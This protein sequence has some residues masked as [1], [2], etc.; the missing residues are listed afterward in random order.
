MR[1]MKHVSSAGRGQ[2]SRK[3]AFR[4]RLWATGDA[5]VSGSKCGCRTLLRPGVGL[6]VLWCQSEELCASSWCTSL[7]LPLCSPDEGGSWRWEGGRREIS[8]WLALGHGVSQCEG[9]EISRPF[10]FSVQV[11][12]SRLNYD[13]KHKIKISTLQIREE[14]D[15]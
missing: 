13:N 15:V 9:S 8:A 11:I 5:A 3:W 2:T 10:C 7:L 1:K 4:W 6:C 12:T 14:D